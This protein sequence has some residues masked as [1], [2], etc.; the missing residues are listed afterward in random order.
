[1][2]Y[3]NLKEIT[4]TAIDLFYNNDFY[5]LEHDVHEQTIS[6]TFAC[7]L[8][9]IFRERNLPWNIDA[10]YN[11]NGERPKRLS[12]IG[13]VKP[14]IIIHV[15]GLNND[16]GIEN[17]NLLI[18]EM[19]KYPSEVAMSDDL[20][21]IQAFMEEAP[22]SYC[23]GVFIGLKQNKNENIYIWKKRED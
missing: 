4:M 23:F 1:M 5:L 7:Y 3:E 14:D 21:K 10:E 13:N 16:L 2:T 15:R 6:S 18:I 17:N 9:G 11:R 8:R 12:G 20:H 19:K 22:F